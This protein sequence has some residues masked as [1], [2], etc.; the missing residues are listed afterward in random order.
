MENLTKTCCFTG[1][2]ML[3]EQARDQLP[4]IIHNKIFELTARNCQTFVT[5]GALGFDTIAARVICQAKEYFPYIRF[6]M[7]LPC[8]TQADR[9]PEQDK[10]IYHHCIKAA[11]KVIYVGEEYT[12]GCM[13]ARNRKMVDMSDICVAYCRS[14][15]G[16]T[17][18]T[19]NYAQRKNLELHFL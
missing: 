10:I 17:A 16:G 4:L 6:V 13:F 2:R 8:K 19:V 15:R 3:S 5:G 7:V 14:Q 11:N 12:S 18:Y 1:H 9:W